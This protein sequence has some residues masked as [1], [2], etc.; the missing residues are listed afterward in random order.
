MAWAGATR[1]VGSDPLGVRW[2]R[3]TVKA[4]GVTRQADTRFAL[5]VDQYHRCVATAVCWMTTICAQRPLAVHHC[6]CTAVP[7]RNID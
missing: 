7:K 2:R 3:R 6:A 4:A 1:L 5:C